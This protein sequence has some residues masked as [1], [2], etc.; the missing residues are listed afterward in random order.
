MQKNRMEPPVERN[1]FLESEKDE[2]FCSCSEN[3]VS[4]RAIKYIFTHKIKGENGKEKSVI[5][6]NLYDAEEKTSL[7]KNRTL[8]ESML[9]KPNTGKTTKDDIKESTLRLF[10]YILFS[11]RPNQDWIELGHYKIEQEINLKKTAYNTAIKQLES[12][13]VIKKAD[14]YR[15]YL[16]HINPAIFFNGKRLDFID[17]NYPKC[18]EIAHTTN[19]LY[20]INKKLNTI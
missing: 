5:D 2:N 16:F 4:F 1:P 6:E 7:F 12:L 18:I 13:S 11:I 19:K 3:V 9:R 10:L 8:L 15:S 20:N 17:K 14:K